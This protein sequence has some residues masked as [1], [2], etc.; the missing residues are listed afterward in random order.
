MKFTLARSWVFALTGALVGSL[1]LISGCVSED[2]GNPATGGT[3]S[4]S[5][6]SGTSTGGGGASSTGGAGGGDPLAV[7]CPTPTMA[8]MTDFSMPNTDGKG[9]SFGDFTNT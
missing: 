3:A 7:A 9:V 8:L 6:G 2:D 4:G 5:G 1:S